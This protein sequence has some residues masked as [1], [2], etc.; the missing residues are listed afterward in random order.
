MPMEHSP[1]S[2]ETTSRFEKLLADLVTAQVD[3]AV[4]GI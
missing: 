2:R 4:L 3:F 1:E